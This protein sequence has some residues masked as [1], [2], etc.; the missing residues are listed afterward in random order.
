MRAKKRLEWSRH[1][2]HGLYSIHDYIAGDNQKA[3]DSVVNH[4]LESAG[5][6][7]DF[8]MLGHE[9]R[10]AGTSELV[11]TKYPY[12]IVYRLTADKVRIVAVIHQ[13]RKY[14]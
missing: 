14:P 11:L 6:L 7:I 9:G 5:R 10:R 4:L 2:E 13:A 3:A 12:T 8:P 1:A